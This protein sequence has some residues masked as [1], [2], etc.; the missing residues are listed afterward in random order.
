[1]AEAALSF[2]C[3][4]AAEQQAQGKGDTGT[5]EVREE[6]KKWG[7]GLVLCIED[8]LSDW[9]TRSSLLFKMKFTGTTRN[10]NCF[11]KGCSFLLLEPGLRHA[12]LFFPIFLSHFCQLMTFYCT[13]LFPRWVCGIPPFWQRQYTK[14][15]C[16]H[17]T[18]ALRFWWV[19][20]ETYPICMLMEHQNVQ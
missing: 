6:L 3:W 11:A 18:A 17:N 13:C 4:S 7:Q 14:T 16:C 12:F 20:G 15:S 10:S 2:V 9:C 1:M 8:A 5:G 19:M